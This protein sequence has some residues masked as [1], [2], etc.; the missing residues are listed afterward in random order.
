MKL[1]AGKQYEQIIKNAQHPP[2]LTKKRIER[3]YK[4][5]ISDKRRVFT[6]KLV[7]IEWINKGY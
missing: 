4:L 7:S 5:L 2:M 6:A 1:Y 3:R